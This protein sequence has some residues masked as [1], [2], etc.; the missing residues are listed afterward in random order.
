[1]NIDREVADFILR[2]VAVAG[3]LLSLDLTRK[4]PNKPQRFCIFCGQ[5]V[6]ISGESKN[7]HTVNCIIEELKKLKHFATLK[8]VKGY[9][10]TFNSPQA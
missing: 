8:A 5:I 7:S 2:T 6:I 4:I 10:M 3:R 9:S 1:M